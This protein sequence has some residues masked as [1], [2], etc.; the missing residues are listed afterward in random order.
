MDLALVWIAEEQTAG[1]APNLAE[2]LAALAH[3]GRIDERQHLLDIGRQE[4]IKQ[5]L[6]GVLNIPEERVSLYVG[7]KC[8]HDLEASHGLV[9]ESADMRRQKTMQVKAIPLGLCEG[10]TLVEYGR[11]EESVTLRLD[12][13]HVL[14]F[15]GFGHGL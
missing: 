8:V 3:G 2:A 5:S 11:V 13:E 12:V 9:L 6:I 7:C 15:G 14:G 10:G 1:L 4:R